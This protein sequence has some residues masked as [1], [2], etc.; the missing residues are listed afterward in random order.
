MYGSATGRVKEKTVGFSIASMTYETI[1][2]A[3]AAQKRVQK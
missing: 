1:T 3:G 2:A